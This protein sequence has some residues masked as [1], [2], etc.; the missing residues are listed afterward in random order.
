MAAQCG[1]REVVSI[2]VV[3]ELAELARENVSTN[4]LGE[5][6]VV[7]QGHSTEMAAL[8]SS[9]A[10]ASAS[11]LVGELLDT[12]LLGEGAIMSMRHA[13]STF[14]SKGKHF[15]A[16]PASAT[17]HCEIIES[18][19]L[20]RRHSLDFVFDAWGGWPMRFLSTERDNFCCQTLRAQGCRSR[21]GP[22]CRT[23]PVF[24]L[25]SL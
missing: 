2:E 12:E 15:T 9:R 16:I 5:K 6:I 17:V 20:W 14:V 11:I 10:S 7:L 25:E 21:T 4:G 24:R 3:P 23:V 13:V 8:S 19:W 18:E 1:A 22:L